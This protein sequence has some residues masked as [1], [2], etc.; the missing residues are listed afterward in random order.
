MGIDADKIRAYLETFNF[1]KLLIDVLG[2]DRCQIRPLNISVNGN[3]YILEAAAEKRG[4]MVFI[5]EPGPDGLIPDKS[6]RRKIEHQVTLTYHEHVIIFVDAAKTTQ[7]WQWVKRNPH[8]PPICRENRF[9][10]GQT[11][12]ALIQRLQT[13]AFT[14]REEPTL[15]IITVSDRARKAFDVENVTKRFYERFKKEHGTF[16]KFIDGIIHQSDQE[17]YA[18]LMLNRMMFIYFIQR[19]GFLDGD[20]NYLKNRLR[21]VQEKNGNGKFH[22][23]YR[24]FL[25]RLFHEGL[26]Q[27]ESERKPELAALLGKVPYLNGGLFD[28]HSLEREYP[29]IQIPDEAFENVFTFFDEF[30]WH[31]D[32]RPLRLDNEINPDVLGYIFEKYINQK[33]MGA[34]YTKEDITGYISRNTIIPY[35]FNAAEK[36]CREAFAPDGP[37]WSLL[38]EEPDRYIYEAVRKGVDEELPPGIADGIENV[39]LR[40]DWNKPAAQ[41]YALPTE[42]WREHIARRKRCLELRDKMKSGVIANIN[43]LITYNLDIT[44]FAQDVIEDCENPEMLRAF[45]VAMAGRIP[46]KSNQG[47]RHGISILDPTCGSGAFLFAALN[48]LEPLYEACLEQMS[49]VKAGLKP[50]CKKYQDFRDILEQIA[51]HPNEKYFVLKSIIIN[52]LYGVDI[53][54]EAVEICKLRL[55]LKLVAQIDQVEHIEPLPD[56]DFNIRAGNTL[57]GFVDYEETRKAIKSKFDFNN[58]LGRIQEDAQNADRTFQRFQQMQTQQ[59][60]P[61]KDFITAKAE[62]RNRLEKLHEELDRYLAVDYG[63]DVNKPGKFDEWRSTHRP[64]HW[65]VEFYGITDKG[66]FDVIIGN[67][68]YIE[69][70]IVSQHYQIKNFETLNCN[71]IFSYIYERSFKIVYSIGRIGFIIPVASL[72]TDR[73]ADLQ[74]LWIMEGN[75]FISNFNDRPGKLFDDLEHIRLSIVLFHKNKINER[76]VYTTKYNKWYTSTRNILFDSLTFA[77][78]TKID[79]YGAISKIG[80]D[81][82]IAI[83]EKIKIANTLEKYISKHGQYKI[84][85]TRKLS[86][87]VQ[88]LDF[89]PL[90]ID[91]NGRK[92]EPSE[93]KELI[94]VKKEIRDVYLSVLNS[95]LFYWFLSVWSDCRNLNKREVYNVPFNFD[96]ASKEIILELQNLSLDLMAEF[97]KN[98]KMLQIN[99]KKWGGM[100]VQCIYPK[101]SKHIIDGIDKALAFHFGF[102][103]EELDFII[104]YDIKY[105]M[106]KDTLEGEEALDDAD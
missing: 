76:Y 61:A 21:M 58:A 36:E 66:G 75:L 89:I 47:F 71:N 93:L 17:W 51:E 50:D 53:M 18:S 3:D 38:K 59:N 9:Q 1:K 94:I 14:L 2:W 42:T 74:K 54:P 65:F 69:Y 40:G 77:K 12:E 106:G 4:F 26:G 11:G 45:W 10:V 24:F 82:E 19:K 37:V 70:K 84:Y 16:L 7:L 96:N 83:L 46:G 34:Y 27:P 68:P 32:E 28:V 43:D 73:Y 87:F 5:A 91:A 95:T 78:A 33:E 29:E 55:F 63:V 81:I 72:C 41:K 98:S 103:K 80:N 99:Y 35:L 64:F 25:L 62:L 57:V 88:I 86:G 105:R 100:G 56:I 49:Q 8:Q 92:R 67:P 104:N 6:I 20:T 22:E 31:L 48:I 39:S 101:F 90:I 97:K 30:N 44:Q 23:F 60:M 102:N 13:I 15:D 79:K 52:N 85:Y